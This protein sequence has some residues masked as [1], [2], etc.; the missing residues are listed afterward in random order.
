[1]FT[2]EANVYINRVIAY[3]QGSIVTKLM[4]FN[5]NNEEGE[6]SKKK[7]KYLICQ[8]YYRNP[9]SA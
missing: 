8:G 3:F 1:M 6:K 7:I 5:K 2:A 4:F 9:Q